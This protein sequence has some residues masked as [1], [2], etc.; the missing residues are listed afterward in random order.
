MKVRFSLAPLALTLVSLFAACD[1]DTATI[2]GNIMPQQDFVSTDQSVFAITTRSVKSKAVV[3]N[4]NSCYLGSVIDP[5][6]RVKTTGSYLAQFHVQEGYKLPLLDMMVR[7]E[8]GKV[9]VDSCVIRILH[10]EYIGDSLTTLKV[11]VQELDTNRVMKENT[12]YYTDLNPADYVSTTSPFTKTVSYSALDQTKSENILS[13][14]TLYRSIPIRM[15][16]AFGERVLNKYY[17]N[18]DFYRNSYRFAHHVCAGFYFQHTG[19]LGAMIKSDATLLD[20]YYRYHSKTKAG[21]D[22]IVVGLQRLASTEEVIQ[23][24]QVE[25]EIPAGLIA[26]NNPFTYI[27]SPAGIYTEAT[28]PVSDIV[29]GTHYSDTINSAT[30]TL[31]TYS[32]E[33]QSRYNL[34]RPQQLLMLRA[35]QAEEFFIKNR[36]PDGKTSFLAPYNAIANSYAYAFSNIGPLISVLRAERDKGAGVLPSDSEAVRKSKWLQWETEHP[37]WNKVVILPVATEYTTTTSAY[38]TTTRTLSRVRNAYGLS[39][40]KLE[41]GAGN[42]IELSVIY[43]RFRQ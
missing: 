7:D 13:N 25:N 5:E 17:E 8:Q 21:K 15:D 1:D 35:S 11:T 19:G 41:G 16:N 34:P 28:I 3:A 31:R 37:D 40:A 20:I 42:P 10:D 9:V 32:A 18:P 29:S 36:L 30:F 27:K 14:A 2:G 4:T 12:K 39:S 43:S 23:N 38:G 26:E 33:E 6:T 24:T 22:T